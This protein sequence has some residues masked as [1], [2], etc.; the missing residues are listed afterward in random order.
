MHGKWLDLSYLN[1]YIHLIFEKRSGKRYWL[2][3]HENKLYEMGICIGCQA[4]KRA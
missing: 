4:K 3:I 2:L 1:V